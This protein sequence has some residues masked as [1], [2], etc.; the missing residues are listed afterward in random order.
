M[1]QPA[2]PPEVLIK[3]SSLCSGLTGTVFKSDMVVC[4]V[5]FGFLGTRP[6]ASLLYV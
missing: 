3:E 2:R 6:V 4:L 5:W 1:C